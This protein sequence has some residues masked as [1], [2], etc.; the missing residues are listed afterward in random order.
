MQDSRAGGLDLTANVPERQLP[1]TEG[2][3]DVWP[4]LI[5]SSRSV[6]PDLPEHD[7]NNKSA[8]MSRH[9]P[10]LPTRLPQ[11]R[12]NS[13]GASSSPASVELM[14]PSRHYKSSSI[15]CK[16][17]VKQEAS[18][19]MGDDGDSVVHTPGYVSGWRVLPH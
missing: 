5:L 9:A 17:K 8:L 4:Y 15:V 12:S 6:S 13:D 3:S 11:A 1:K 16:S 2:R 19:T 14:P 18:T 10:L 7:F